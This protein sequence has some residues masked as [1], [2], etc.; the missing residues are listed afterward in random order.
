MWCVP[1]I[2]DEFKKRMRDLLALFQ[3]PR[4]EL[5]PVVCVD[6]KSVELHDEKYAVIF[7]KRGSLRDYEYVRKGTANVFVATEPKGG[8]H[9][10]RVTKR[11]TKR[12]FA[13]F[14]RWL[15][16]RFPNALRIHL[17]MDN[18]NTHRESSLTETYG[19]RE[20]RALWN[21]FRVHYTPKHAS[22]LNPAEI[23]INVMT[24]CCI[25][26][27]RIPNIEQLRK[28]VVAFWRDRRRERWL[29]HWRFTVEAGR[30][31][32]VSVKITF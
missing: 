9:F 20:G 26:R 32:V 24:R 5:F 11:R 17:V 8:R 12:D 15:A 27:R 2:D 10:G 21:R 30:W 4:S 19:E 3:R 22:W 18:L 7:R 31:V 6:E 13:H 16:N 25:G 1:V 23:A 29:I 28:S 14:L